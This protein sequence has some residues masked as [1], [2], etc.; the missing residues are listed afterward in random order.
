M[1]ERLPFPIDLRLLFVM[2]TLD[3]ALVAIHVGLRALVIVDAIPSVPPILSTFGDIGL[4]ER[5]NHG[6]WILVIV[7]MVLTFSRTQAPLFLSIAVVFGLIFAD[8]VFQVHEG[9]SAMIQA[10]WPAMPT[11]GMLPGQAGELLVWLALGAV[12]LPIIAWGLVRTERLWWTLAAGIG[13]GFAGLIL[14]AVIFD[15]MQEPLHHIGHPS[16]RYW[17]LYLAGLIES[18]GESLFASLT[19]AS[20]IGIWMSLRRAHAVAHDHISG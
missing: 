20:A 9:G 5:F 3:L 17:L 15:T 8:D 12:T 11:F 2:V 4:A 10:A 13:V 19:A 1:I 7:M 16:L 6:K 18:A 14:F